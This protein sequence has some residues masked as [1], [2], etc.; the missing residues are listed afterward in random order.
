MHSYDDGAS[1]MMEIGDRS[2]SPPFVGSRSSI[3]GG[4]FFGA[5]GG[6]QVGPK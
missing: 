5:A 6:G 4:N 2:P 3:G 1:D